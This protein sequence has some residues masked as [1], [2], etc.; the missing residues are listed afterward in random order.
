MLSCNWIIDRGSNCKDHLWRLEG[1]FAWVV[2]YQSLSKR[3]SNKHWKTYR[4]IFLGRW[5]SR[6]MPSLFSKNFQFYEKETGN[7]FCT[8][9][10]TIGTISS[11]AVFFRDFTKPSKYNKVKYFLSGKE[12]KADD[13]VL[14]FKHATFQQVVAHNEK[15][16]R[17]LHYK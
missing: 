7:G 5:K 13:G 12:K 16:V 11:L 9:Q 10:S 4:F 17:I 3:F 14:D 2:H 6:L 15:L 1:R 8:F